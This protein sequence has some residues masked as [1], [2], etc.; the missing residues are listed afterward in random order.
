METAEL[1]TEFL[2]RPPVL[3]LPDPGLQAPVAH[4]PV[5]TTPY[6]TSSR[7]TSASGSPT[8]LE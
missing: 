7:T 2:C 8:T 3:H 6:R 4:E 1:V 5:A